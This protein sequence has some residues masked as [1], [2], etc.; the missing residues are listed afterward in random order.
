MEAAVV[1]L[2]VAVVALAV[3]LARSEAQLRAIARFLVNRESASNARGFP[4]GT[5]S[6][7]SSA[8]RT[9]EIDAARG[10]G[11]TP[12]HSGNPS[13][14]VSTSPS[15]RAVASMRRARASWATM[16]R[17]RPLPPPP[18]AASPW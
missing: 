9:G 1:L 7:G 14:T 18:R 2:A 16:A 17:P 4:S 11:S 10:I 15:R 3:Q 8:G 5:A 12:F 13:S 6:C